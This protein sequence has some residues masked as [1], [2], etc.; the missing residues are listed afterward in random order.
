MTISRAIAA[1]ANGRTMLAEL[2]KVHA[3]DVESDLERATFEPADIRIRRMRSA[4]AWN[5]GRAGLEAIRIGYGAFGDTILQEIETRGVRPA[6]LEE[7]FLFLKADP[8][9]VLRGHAPLA[10]IGSVAYVDGI[11]CAVY[12]AKGKRGILLRLH[13]FVSDWSSSFWF[14]VAPPFPG[15]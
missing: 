5:P 1:A 12:A 10:A 11:A 13:R 2:Q 6:T 4:G 8:D 15:A 7:L 9:A 3:A 14:L